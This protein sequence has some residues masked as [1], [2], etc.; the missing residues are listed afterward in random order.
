MERK[1]KVLIVEDE[2]IIAESIKRSLEQMGYKVV[3]IETSGIKAIEACKNLNPDIAVMDIKLE[4]EMNGIEAAE[5]IYS[6]HNIPTIYLTSYGDQETISEAV[7]SQTFGYILKPFED[8]ELHAAIEMALYKFQMEDKLRKNQKFLKQ[9]IDTSPN[10]MYVYDKDKKYLLANEALGKFLHVDHNSMIGKNLNQIFTGEKSVDEYIRVL[11]DQFNGLNEY[12][13]TTCNGSRKSFKMNKIDIMSPDNKPCSLSVAMDITKLKNAENEL[14]I[15]YRKLEKMFRDTVKALASAAEIRDP[16]TA[17]HQRR[18]ADLAVKI[19]EQMSLDQNMINGI[20]L[21]ALIHDIGKIL[22]PVEILNKPGKLSDP[23]LEYIKQHSQE[24]YNNLKGIEFPWPVAEI[25]LQHHEKID[26]S[27]YPN[28][29]KDDEIVIEAKIICVAD[30]I[31]AM[32]SHRPYRPSQGI[33]SALKEIEINRG[34]LYDKRV[35]DICLQLFKE[36]DYKFPSP[37]V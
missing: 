14:K 16:Y 9:I 31:E 22:I 11:H 1:R 29:L 27:G 19:A 23:E 15:S 5:V 13:I 6:Q 10:L 20:Y 12:E 2:L 7:R 34:I 25:I 26:G 18:V 30:V 3:A 24:G 17:G 36:L 21:T 32:A 28:N 4:G 33:E 37:E 35:V 8:K